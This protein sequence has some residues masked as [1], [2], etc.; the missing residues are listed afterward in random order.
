MYTDEQIKE[1]DYA[2]T[3]KEINNTVDI[4]VTLRTY[5]TKLNRRLKKA[6]IPYHQRLR[7]A[8]AAVREL[9]VWAKQSQENTDRLMTI[10]DAIKNNDPK[11]FET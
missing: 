8:D 6:S 9:S 11:L 3:V 4:L 5:K 7:E 2:T 10:R 1:L